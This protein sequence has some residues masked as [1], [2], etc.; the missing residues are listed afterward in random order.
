MA[1]LVFGG[2]LIAECWNGYHDAEAEYTRM[3]QKTTTFL[4]DDVLGNKNVSLLDS[5]RDYNPDTESESGSVTVVAR[6]TV[7][8][9]IVEGIELS[10]SHRDLD[11][12]WVYPNA[13][14]PGYYYN[15]GDGKYNYSFDK[16]SVSEIRFLYVLG[17]VLVLGGGLFIISMAWSLRE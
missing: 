12:S 1:V 7:D 8:D 15:A 14:I 4:V 5:W 6:T 17:G 2:M 16:M 3:D 11:A 9:K 10:R 13:E